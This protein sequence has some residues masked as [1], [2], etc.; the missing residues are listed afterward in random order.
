MLGTLEGRGGKRVSMD[1]WVVDRCSPG[2]L[3]RKFRAALWTVV[4]K[5]SSS[6]AK[7]DKPR[8][9]ESFLA[10]VR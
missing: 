1:E 2:N 8:T 9:N 3:A 7:I 4:G 10:R 6:A 5:R